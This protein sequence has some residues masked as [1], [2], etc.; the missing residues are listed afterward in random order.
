MRAGEASMS[1]M[2]ASRSGCS[3]RD[4]APGVCGKNGLWRLAVAAAACVV[5]T[6]CTRGAGPAEP[7]PMGPVPVL[8]MELSEIFADPA[9][10][11][12]HW[13]VMVQSLETGE[14]FYRQNVDKLF[15][16]ASNNKLIT[17]A[18][19]LARLGADHRFT[20]RVAA[21]GPISENGTLEGDLVVVGGGDPAISERFYDDD[22]TAAFRDWAD[23]LK[24]R[25]IT[26]I[27]GDVIGDDD[28]SL[29]T[30]RQ[31]LGSVELP[32]AGAHA[33]ERSH[34]VTQAIKGLD[35]MVA[36]VCHQETSAVVTVA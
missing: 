9:F 11:N 20:T 36:A 4:D 1:A 27:S 33:T 15:M 35:A 6:G 2:R 12:A 21:T 32:I 8:R 18:V 3:G 5:M 26:R 34:R 31:S 28:L 22:P 14:V 23:S 17:A 10:G 16:P 24:A 7:V 25:G 29:G 19:S 30:Y 13:G